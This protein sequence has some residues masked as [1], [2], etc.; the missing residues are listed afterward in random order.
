[1]CIFN[2][3]LISFIKA[4]G[5]GLVMIIP[6]SSAKGTVLNVLFVIFFVGYEGKVRKAKVHVSMIL[7]G[8]VLFFPVT[9]L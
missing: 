7:E 1:V 9:V 5:L 8:H 3:F 6:V 4:K 2:T